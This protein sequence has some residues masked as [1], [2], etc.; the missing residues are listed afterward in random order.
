MRFLGGIMIIGG[1]LGLG[2]WY[3]EQFVGRINALRTL[4]LILEML[5]SEIRYGKSALPECCR[6]MSARLEEP[7]SSC[8]DN[9]CGVLGEG[10]G[11]SFSNIFCGSMESCLK[12]LPL[13]KEDRDIFLQPFRGQGFQDGAMQLKNMEQALVRITDIIALLERERKERCNM[14]VGLGAMSGLL[15]VIILF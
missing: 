4:A 8:L 5:M 10:K 1:C 12:N 13:K 15:L 11:D 14:A 2:L 6:N 9:V 3:R 7:Y